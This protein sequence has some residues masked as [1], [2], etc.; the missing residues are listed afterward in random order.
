MLGADTILTDRDA[1]LQQINTNIALNGANIHAAGGEARTMPLD[2]RMECH[3]AALSPLAV[4][5]FDLLIG[6]DLIYPA[7]SAIYSKLLRILAS[8]PARRVIMAYPYKRDRA[9]AKF[10]EQAASQGHEVQ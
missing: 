1:L 7:T 6:S 3:L 8:L 4:P 9:P 10:F 5:P 2:W